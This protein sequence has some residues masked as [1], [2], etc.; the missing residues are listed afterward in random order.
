M[1]R[2]VA[3]VL[4]ALLLAPA[5]AAARV[6]CV[7]PA[8]GAGCDAT[9]PVSALQAA[10]DDAA[11]DGSPD[12]VRLGAASYGRS[13]S[14]TSSDGGGLTL[15]GAGRDATFL[16]PIAGA[17]TLDVSGTSGPVRL[18][19]LTVR[20]PGTS[21]A[22]GVRGGSGRLD[23][24]RVDVRNPDLVPSAGATGVRF[25]A[26]G[27]S[28]TDGTAD[29][30][31][32]GEG[33]AIGTL[34]GTVTLTEVD[35]LGA[36]GIDIASRTTLN[37]RRSTVR[38]S[39]KGIL[40]LDATTIDLRDTV[41]RARPDSSRFD[42]I[43]VTSI[44]PTR[45]VSVTGRNVTMV[46]DGAGVGVLAATA[47]GGSAN[48]QLTQS[49]IAGFATA[50]SAQG[51]NASIQTTRSAYDP[52][53]SF[54][55]GGGTVANGPGPDPLLG[56]YRFVS[57]GDLRPRFDSPLV[58]AGNPAFDPGAGALDLGGLERR[59]GAA[60]DIGAHEYGRRPPS[61]E[62]SVTPAGEGRFA[63]A[64][65]ASDP[66]PGDDVAVKW[67]F[68]DGTSSSEPAP[69]HA[70]AP[71]SYT[72]TA[73]ATD[74]TGLGATRSGTLTVPRPPPTTVTVTTPGAPVTTTP[75]PA[76]PALRLTGASISPARFRRSSKRVALRFTLSRRAKVALKVE[77]R[78][79]RRFAP[80]GSWRTTAT[81]AAGA[82][83]VRVAPR[84]KGRTLRPGT[85]R[86]TLTA[87]AGST[88]S[89][90]VRVAF[91]VLR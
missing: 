31:A 76:S 8:G 21:G 22:G 5:S 30:G 53:T 78:R 25:G 67:D 71:G 24:E 16:G 23:L 82:R 85:Y 62:A 51:A 27:G 38:A 45:P 35:A 44:D 39:R 60:V 70:Y 28:W 11:S 54:A 65:L 14:F 72:W 19:D 40:R 90:P 26:P 33:T 15:I 57:A 75:P 29:A 80:A 2:L 3:A 59:L 41:L 69:S 32:Q 47:A 68:G 64:A 91:T 87:L 83:S 52:A 48:V 20:Q 88:R 18:V 50:L 37:V 12:V 86:L 61:L 1:P 6:L 7:E 43:D 89:R 55:T 46:G 10:L 66:D 9:F 79:G 34:A 74:P 81:L 49:V 58:D 36:T 17:T 13:G 56:P 73:Q 84:I 42:A 4:A 77:R 63:F